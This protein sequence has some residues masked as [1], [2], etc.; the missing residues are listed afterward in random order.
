M[1]ILFDKFVLE[2]EGFN[3]IVHN[4]PINTADSRNKVLGLYW[5]VRS[6]EICSDAG[7]DVFCLTD[8][9]HIFFFA[10]EQVDTRICRDTGA[11]EF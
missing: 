3:L 4:N 5:L 1:H 6:G 11:L 10:L 2:Q 9:E 7:T 8:V